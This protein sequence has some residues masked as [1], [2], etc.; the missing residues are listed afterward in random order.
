MFTENF[1]QRFRAKMKIQSAIDNDSWTIDT[2]SLTEAA[3][4]FYRIR[5]LVFL[6]KVLNL[7]QE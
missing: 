1:I 7:S 4:D 3:F 5:K 2:V 6:D